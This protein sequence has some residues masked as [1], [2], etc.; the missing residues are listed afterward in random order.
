MMS[1][2]LT[3]L[4]FYEQSEHLVQR[5]SVG[6]KKKSQSIVK[7]SRYAH[8][9]NLELEMLYLFTVTSL[10]SLFFKVKSS[11]KSRKWYWTID[12]RGCNLF[13]STQGEISGAQRGQ[14][15]WWRGI[16]WYSAWQ[17][18]AHSKWWSET[19][20]W[21]RLS[22][23]IS[24]FRHPAKPQKHLVKTPTL[25]TWQLFWASYMITQTDIMVK[26]ALWV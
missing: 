4:Y 9:F 11:T 10:F 23:P 17:S 16:Q 25:D 24:M 12:I 15:A 3:H 21:A 19:G 13:I 14:S 2:I 7:V 18:S 20:R 6:E 5:F 1:N 8:S 26:R 22:I